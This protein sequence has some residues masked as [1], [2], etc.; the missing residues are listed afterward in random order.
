MSN[1][2]RYTVL[3]SKYC[4]KCLGVGALWGTVEYELKGEGEVGMEIFLDEVTITPG[5]TGEELKEGIERNNPGATTG[6]LQGLQ[7]KK[8]KKE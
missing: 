7:E 3:Y 8:S 4:F 1:N 2:W 6:K 5:A